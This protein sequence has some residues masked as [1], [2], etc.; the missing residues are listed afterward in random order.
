MANMTRAIENAAVPEPIC[1]QP[2]RRA[3]PVLYSRGC[4]ED[5]LH[6]A[7]LIVRPDC[8]PPPVVSVGERRIEAELLHRQN[9]LAVLRYSFS[10][11]AKWGGTYA[12]DDATFD[13]AGVGEGDLRL[14][15]V[16]CN[17][18]ERG[19]RGRLLT[20]R[21]TMWRRLVRW[22][23]ERPLNVML[24]GGDQLYADE[25]LDVHPEVR[26][27]A[28]RERP[29]DESRTPSRCV[30]QKLR[31]FFFQRYLQLYSQPMPAWLHARVPSL[32]M[33]DDHDICD[34]W[35]S[36]AAE[37]LDAPIGKEVFQVAR[38]YFLLFQ[39]GGAGDHLPAICRDPQGTTLTWAM[40]LPGTLLVAPDLRSERRPDRVLGPAGWA[41]LEASLAGT[42]DVRHVFV[43]SSVPLLGPRLSWVEAVLHL[44]P[45][46]QKY[47]DDLRD[48]WQSQA[49]RDEWQRM[50]R[51]LL[52][53]HERGTTVVVL[54]GEIHLATRGTMATGAGP[55]HQLTA[56]GIAHPPPTPWYGRTLGALARLGEAPLP[57]HPIQL[58]PLPGRRGIYTSQRNFLIL[59][60]RSGRWSAVW[61]LEH[62]GA[63]PPLM[64]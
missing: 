55:L 22:H 38:E 32:C 16:S 39:L 54:S 14:A 35:G 28:D 8:E 33:W 25:A 20:E 37:R 51:T 26:A 53:L 13:V 27:W 49:H 52:K 3:G 10:L 64:L 45:G 7:A 42:G 12:V 57:A 47:E 44:L 61:E 19:D 60:R 18:Q 6:L 31:D 43:L 41:A 63:T 40:E 5:R 58:H 56:S 59:E 24:H 29:V 50:L 36:L 21:N 17:G 2:V 1:E 34:G 62:D 4:S 15:Y 48:Q 23:E 30:R 9:D 11:P 46:M